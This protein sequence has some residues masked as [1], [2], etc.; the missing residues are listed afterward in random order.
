MSN[1][2]FVFVCTSFNSMLLSLFKVT[3]NTIMES[4]LENAH[5]DAF[6]NTSY[7]LCK[8]LTVIILKVKANI[9]QVQ[10]CS[11]CL[12]MKCSRGITSLHFSNDSQILKQGQR[13]FTNFS[14][15]KKTQFIL[16]PASKLK[17]VFLIHHNEARICGSAPVDISNYLF[18]TLSRVMVVRLSQTLWRTFIF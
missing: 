18:K 1:P 15:K 8:P 16:L 3:H 5:T 10:P 7:T 11:M 14:M 6:Q 12:H 13:C 9:N 17:A 2:W 4:Q